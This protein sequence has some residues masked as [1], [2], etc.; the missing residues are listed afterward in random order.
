MSLVGIVPTCSTKVP[1][2]SKGSVSVPPILTNEIPS[3]AGSFSECEVPT[4][5]PAKVSYVGF[6]VRSPT[7]AL[8][9]L[10]YDMRA[11]VVESSPAESVSLKV[12]FPSMT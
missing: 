8:S 6:T 12:L 7:R 5:K 4:I 1:Y 3:L 9:A 10:A 2:F 11:D